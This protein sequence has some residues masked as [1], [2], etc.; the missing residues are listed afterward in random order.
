MYISNKGDKKEKSL[1]QRLKLSEN[2]KNSYRQIKSEMREMGKRERK[3][4]DEEDISRA[5]EL[6]C[7][8][9]Q[10]YHGAGG[11]SGDWAFSALPL[12][13]GFGSAVFALVRP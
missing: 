8:S 1:P 4:Q 2:Q 5:R 7:S 13:L 9:Y 12:G 11:L 10:T 6:R 3:G